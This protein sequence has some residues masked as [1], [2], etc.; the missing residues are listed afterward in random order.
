M[1]I[2]NFVFLDILWGMLN[3]DVN[4]S[5]WCNITLLKKMWRKKSTYKIQGFFLNGNR[6]SIISDSAAMTF[7]KVGWKGDQPNL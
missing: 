3:L 4:F 6:Y 7:W 1:V 5:F 2:F